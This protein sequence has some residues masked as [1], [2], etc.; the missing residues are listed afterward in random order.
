MPSTGGSSGHK[1]SKHYHDTRGIKVGSGEFVR[2]GTILTRQ[3]NIWKAG[4]N[5]GDSGTLYALCDGKV[6]FTKRR[7]NYNR[8]QTYVN[9]IPAKPAKEKTGS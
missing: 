8:T 2:T 1:K 5:V 9:I 4:S 3:G 7:G 6:S